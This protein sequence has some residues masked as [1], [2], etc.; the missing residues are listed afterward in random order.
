MGTRPVL[1]PDAPHTKLQ[2]RLADGRRVQITLNN[3]AP[4]TDVRCA[5]ES[6]MYESWLAQG[7]EGAWTC[8]PFDLVAGFPPRPLI[9]D[10]GVTIAGHSPSLL[11]AAVTQRMLPQFP[12]TPQ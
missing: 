5:V 12:S 2:V 10:H 8:P 4:V 3:D 1:R 11:G 9:Y 6:E 7:C